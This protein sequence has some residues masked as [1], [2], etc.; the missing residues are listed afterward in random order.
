MR[1]KIIKF[2][3]RKCVLR[4]GN[5]FKGWKSWRQ[6]FYNHLCKSVNFSFMPPVVP[7]W[8]LAHP[9]I[10]VICAY[11]FSHSTYFSQKWPK[12]FRWGENL[13]KGFKEHI[14]RKVGTV[15]TVLSKSICACDSGQEA[16][17]PPGPKCILNSVNIL[18]LIWKKLESFQILCEE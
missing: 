5:N 16:C 4:S 13:L 6:Y 3:G 2:L 12:A 8:A 10:N 1:T 18:C 17:S 9:Y 11:L 7:T 15:V 14:L